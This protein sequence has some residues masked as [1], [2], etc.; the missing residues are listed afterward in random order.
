MTIEQLKKEFYNPNKY[1]ITLLKHSLT[2]LKNHLREMEDKTELTDVEV[3]QLYTSKICL[4]I[5]EGLIE[6]EHNM[7]H[8]QLV[9]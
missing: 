7:R 5:I 4:W 3:H 8:L 9:A 1:H 2:C 6:H